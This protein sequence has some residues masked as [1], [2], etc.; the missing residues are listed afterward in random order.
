MLI[1]FKDVMALVSILAFS[2]TT[3]IWLDQLSRIV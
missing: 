3:L 1:W 2:G